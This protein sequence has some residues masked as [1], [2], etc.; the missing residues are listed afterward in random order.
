MLQVQILSFRPES[1]LVWLAA[2]LKVT[3]PGTQTKVPLLIV[4]ELLCR[5]CQVVKPETEFA[6]RNQATNTKQTHCKVCQK[7]FDLKTKLNP[8]YLKRKQQDK[9]K[10]SEK[11]QKLVLE[12]LITHFCVDCGE[13]DP[14]VLEFD[15][16][17]NKC[18]S[19][20]NLVKRRVSTQ[21]LL[22]EIAKCEIR[23]ANCHRR[24]TSKQ[25]KWYKSHSSD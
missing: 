4:M 19:I 7:Q 16:I 22:D 20:A 24:K 2:R 17:Q 5:K 18:D 3:R 1:R 10:Q 6:W 23:C 12:Y 15:H 11:L 14:V 9:Q 8:N 21:T 25:L 13:K